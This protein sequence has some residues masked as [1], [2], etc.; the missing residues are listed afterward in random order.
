MRVRRSGSHHEGE[1]HVLEA[2]THHVRQ[3]RASSH[4]APKGS[5]GN[6]DRAVRGRGRGRIQIR[7]ASKGRNGG[8]KR[9]PDRLVSTGGRDRPHGCYPGLGDAGR[10]DI[11][12]DPHRG[13]GAGQGWKPAGKRKNHRTFDL[14]RS[15]S[16]RRACPRERLNRRGRAIRP[17]PTRGIATIRNTHESPIAITRWGFRVSRTLVLWP[18]N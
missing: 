4:D 16:D 2:T 6:N 17:V 1:H 10:G 14:A 18:R 15:A 9:R 11:G 12:V 13:D 7:L 3:P 5:A 8:Y